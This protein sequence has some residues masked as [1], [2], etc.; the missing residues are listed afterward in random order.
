MNEQEITSDEI[1][2]ENDNKKIG[3]I[4]SHKIEFMISLAL[5]SFMLFLMIVLSTIESDNVKPQVSVIQ[6]VEEPPIELPP[7]KLEE[8]DPDLKPVEVKDT[9]ESS[10]IDEKTEVLVNQPIDK[11]ETDTA[12]SDDN[13]DLNSIMAGT[14]NEVASMPEG[15]VGPN[16]VGYGSP[17]GGGLPH[18]YKSRG[19]KGKDGAMK[20]H[21]GSGTDSSVELALKW[22]KY[23]QESDGS[24]DAS[25]Y[26]GR[27][28]Y[29]PAM[30]ACAL[31]AF[32]GAGYSENIGPYKD[33][34]HRGLVWLNDA[35]QS[36][37]EKPWFDNGYGTGMVLMAL[38]EASIFGSSSQTK[39]N[40]NIVAKMVLD[41]YTEKLGWRYVPKSISC[42]QSVSGWM[43]L[44]LK[45]AKAAELEALGPANAKQVKEVFDQYT[46]WVKSMTLEGTGLGCY[47]QPV[48]GGPNMTW[49]GM[50]QRMFLGAKKD[51]AYLV[52]AGENTIGWIESNKWIGGDKPGDVYGIYYGTLACFQRQ[53]PVWK[54]WNAKM[55]PTLLNSQRKG[56]PQLMGG[57]WDPTPGHT[58]EAG[59]RV[60]TT[61][62][63]CLCLEV[64]Y[65]YEM[66]T[67]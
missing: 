23:H 57:S 58:G 45:S 67:N 16:G 66:M 34:V 15:I 59:G 21:G 13:S 33:T 32:L 48:S 37:G 26:E 29:K 14:T 24:W 65:R 12:G 50:F 11:P 52:K 56:D 54:M 19:K 36:K 10:D 40:A 30:T 31:L 3:F 41:S 28:P 64:Y 8:R 43:A 46:E 6:K 51:D 60:I 27:A 44:G 25:K 22:L 5:H 9:E 63:L 62:L 20:K 17:D 53:E 61:A 1:V 49:V 38:S 2:Q 4:A 18:G 35:I 47:G 55:K 42:D 7:K 39:T